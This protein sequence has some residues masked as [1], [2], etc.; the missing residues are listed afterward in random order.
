MKVY[1]VD[2]NEPGNLRS[3]LNFFDAGR[4]RLFCMSRPS[5]RGVELTKR[6]GRGMMPPVAGVRHRFS[7]NF[8][9]RG[10]P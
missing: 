5:N 3:S 7:A 2:L 8:L 10:N 9:L 4:Y 1:Q 6:D